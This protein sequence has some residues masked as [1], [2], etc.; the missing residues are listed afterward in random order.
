M[1]VIVIVIVILIIRE[2]IILN[3]RT[4][5]T[6]IINAIFFHAACLFLFGSF[7]RLN[8]HMTTECKPQN[9]DDANEQE[10]FRLR[11]SSHSA[12]VVQTAAE[13]FLMCLAQSTTNRRLMHSLS[14]GTLT[15]STPDQFEIISKCLENLGIGR[16]L[17]MTFEK[18]SAP[19]DE[20]TADREQLTFES[21]SSSSPPISESGYSISKG[22]SAPSPAIS[23]S[24]G[25]LDDENQAIDLSKGQHSTASI[26]QK[27]TETTDDD[28]RRAPQGNGGG[29]GGEKKAIGKEKAA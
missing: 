6:I 24:L 1:I 13:S 2:A 23:S 12:S 7:Y 20:Q 8:R 11:V 27:G 16:A 29:G 19:M 22:Q 25:S 3:T 9:D 26:Q 4:I 18:K 21:S 14:N 17:T 28:D 15:F 5:N 10:H